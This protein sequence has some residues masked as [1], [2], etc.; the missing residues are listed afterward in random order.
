MGHRRVRIYQL[1]QRLY[2]RHQD[3]Q[4][5]C[6]QLQIPAEHHL[7]TVTHLEAAQIALKLPPLE[8]VSRDSNPVC[9]PLLSSALPSPLPLRRR[10]WEP[11]VPETDIFAQIRQQDLLVHQ[12]D[13]SATSLLSAFV[14]QAASDPDVLAIKLLIDQAAIA[15]AFP[16]E[17]LPGL[18]TAIESGKQVI[19]L[20]LSS[21]LQSQRQAGEWVQQLQAIGVHVMSRL[22][23]LPACQNLMLVV[24][25]EALRL[26][27]YTY[28]CADPDSSVDSS[29]A[30]GMLS[31]QEPLGADVSQFFNQLTGKSVVPL[32]G[33][34]LSVS[35]S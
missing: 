32:R 33:S 13:T 3:V 4:R 7:G 24:R 28:L 1:A 8:S 5:V 25:R 27:R 34:C 17:L 22:M 16:T 2:C 21:T 15:T 31:C 29:A 12:A 10:G 35:A 14:A 11:S 26:R 9:C 18:T 19:V 20:L 23:V 6:Q 30:V